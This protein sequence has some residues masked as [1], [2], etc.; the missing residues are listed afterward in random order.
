MKR[1]VLL[2]KKDERMDP[3][4]NLSM[5]VSNLRQRV[6]FLEEEISKLERRLIEL[7]VPVPIYGEPNQNNQ[8]YNGNDRVQ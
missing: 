6:A 3:K 1:A 2:S 7:G 8:K 4:Y 5:E